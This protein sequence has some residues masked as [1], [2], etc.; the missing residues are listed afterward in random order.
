MAS[1]RK[2]GKRKFLADDFI[3]KDGLLYKRSKNPRDLSKM[4]AFLWN[5][6]EV[7]TVSTVRSPQQTCR[8]TA[9]V[10]PSKG[11]DASES[12]SPQDAGGCVP[13]SVVSGDM[14][15]GRADCQEALVAEASQVQ[16]TTEVKSHLGV[17]WK[18]HGSHASPVEPDS[19]SRVSVLTRSA[20]K[21]KDIQ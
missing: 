16:S 6:G 17:R 9:G 8:C 5:R 15:K 14:V 10:T 1:E 4:V 19:H 18:D 21:D 3:I 7:D 11:D 20:L 2:R 12:L 13:V